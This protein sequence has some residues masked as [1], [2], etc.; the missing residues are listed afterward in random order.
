MT[1]QSYT[2]GPWHNRPNPEPT[3][4]WI[5]WVDGPAHKD[6]GIGKPIAN[7][8]RYYNGETEANA[9]LIAAAPEMV[10]ALGQIATELEAWSGRAASHRKEILRER[11]NNAAHRARIVLAKI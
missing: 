6:G 11:M 2:P 8:F 1:K 7:L 9:R 4:D 10:E 5:W 3:D